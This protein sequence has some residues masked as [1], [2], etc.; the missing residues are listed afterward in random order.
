ME[1]SLAVRAVGIPT[2]KEIGAMFW[3]ETED[4]LFYYSIGPYMGDGQN[5]PNVDSRF[6]IFG[7]T[8]V[9]PLATIGLPKD[10]PLRDFQVGVSGHYGSRDK[11]WVFY[12]Y[13]SLT[14]QGG[15]TFFSTTY[16]GVNGPTH[17]IPSGDQLAFAGELRLPVSRFDLTAELVYIRNNTREILEGYEPTNSERFGRISGTSYY[18]MVGYWVFGKR[19]INGVPGYGNPPRLDWSANDP[20]IPDT[21]LQIL[22]KWEQVHLA[23]ASASRGALG[24]VDTKGVDG[25]IIANALSFGANYWATKH[26]RLSLNYVLSMFPNSGP[27]SPSATGGPVQTTA[28]RAQA[29][30]N[31]LGKGIDDGARDNAHSL[32]E[33][34]ARFAIAL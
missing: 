34:L 2:N 31:T 30:G 27:T 20:V 10:Q 4:R 7:R 11:N 1:R 14:T 16:T 9:H 32:H 19:D 18:A 26:V 29:P 15:Y 6:D 13:P 24:V 12:D 33:L 5:R 21:A 25:D 17:I 3:G 23:Y 8:F 22:G 28:N